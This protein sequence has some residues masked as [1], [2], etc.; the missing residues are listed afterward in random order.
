MTKPIHN[1][2]DAGKYPSNPLTGAPPAFTEER[3]RWGQSKEEIC[4]ALWHW[5]LLRRHKLY[6]DHWKSDSDE[7]S[8]AFRVCGMPRP[9]PETD[10]PMDLLFDYEVFDKPLRF[11]TTIAWREVKNSKPED[12][13]G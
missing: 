6:Q 9:N 2:K 3:E 11:Q 13:G 10:F 7:Y 4:L 8:S 5:Q 12:F 1:W